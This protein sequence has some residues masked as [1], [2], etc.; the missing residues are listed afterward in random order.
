ML[1]V[2]DHRWPPWPDPFYAG[3]P[4]QVS[5]ECFW[6]VVYLQQ[7]LLR[8]HAL[9]LC[10]GTGD[11][12]RRFLQENITCF[13]SNIAHHK[14]QQSLWCTSTEPIH[15]MYWTLLIWQILLL[16]HFNLFACS[17]AVQCVQAQCGQR[18]RERQYQ[19]DQAHNFAINATQSPPQS[20]VVRGFAGAARESWRQTAFCVPMPTLWKPTWT[21]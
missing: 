20:P 9:L 12:Y 5:L 11:S 1:A 15:N 13:L 3:R 18:T 2:P 17:S 8:H 6:M 16:Q 4:R 7:K 10:Y 21:G 19:L 14:A